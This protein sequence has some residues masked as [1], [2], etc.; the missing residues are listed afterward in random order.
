MTSSSDQRGPV[1]RTEHAFTSG[2]W[3]A[4]GYGL[5]G[6]MTVGSVA[7]LARVLSPDGF[8][9]VSAAMLAINF[10]RGFSEGA[11]APPG[12]Q[13]PQLR[14]EHNQTAFTLPLGASVLPFMRLW[15][16]APTAAGRL[17]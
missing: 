1:N 14:D 5:Q 10:S 16:W 15:L 13:H 11:I 9:L 7:V 2:V 4:A 12:V 3:T 8:G 17:T 6:L